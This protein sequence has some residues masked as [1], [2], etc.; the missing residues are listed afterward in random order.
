M[1]GINLKEAILKE[2]NGG[3]DIILALYPDAHNVVQ[4][5]AKKFKMRPDERTASATLRQK[6]D[7]NYYVCSEFYK[8]WK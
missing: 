6:S 2:T 7:G 1:L 5:S 3:L 8:E 4:G